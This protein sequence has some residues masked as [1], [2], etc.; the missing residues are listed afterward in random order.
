MLVDA[1][2]GIPTWYPTQFITTQQIRNPGN[3]PTQPTAHAAIRTG[4]SPAF[5][6]KSQ[7]SLPAGFP[8]LLY[9]RM[10]LFHRGSSAAASL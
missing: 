3:H 2:T 7:R 9:T 10:K 5:E 1:K 4:P 6:A 8:D